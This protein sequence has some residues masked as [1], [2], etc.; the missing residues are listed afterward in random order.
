MIYVKVELWPGG[1]QSRAETIAE[2]R[3]ANVSKLAA[4]SDYDCRV[5]AKGW[6]P[7]N[8]VAHESRFK[9]YGHDRNQGILYLLKRVFARAVAE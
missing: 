1:D 5:T 2:A 9:L 6:A 4:S 3:V 8:I 7:L